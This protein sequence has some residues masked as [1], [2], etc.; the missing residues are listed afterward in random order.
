MET[1]QGR[2][3]LEMEPVAGGG[4]RSQP[5]AGIRGCLAPEFL[6]ERPHVGALTM[7][8]F[9]VPGVPL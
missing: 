7:V 9:V 6:W 4:P 1:E 5:V 3:S 8:T 2:R